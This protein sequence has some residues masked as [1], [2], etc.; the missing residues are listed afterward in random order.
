M[1]TNKWEKKRD[2]KAA[3]NNKQQSSQ[4]TN[5]RELYYDFKKCVETH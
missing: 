4:R 3:L 2:R 1:R 5:F